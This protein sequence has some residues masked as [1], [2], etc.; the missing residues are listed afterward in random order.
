MS[1]KRTRRGRPEGSG[2]DDRARLQAIA[3][4]ISANPELKPTT[5]IRTLGI[6]DPSVIRRLRDKFKAVRP[7]LMRDLR[8]TQPQERTPA[9]LKSRRAMAASTRSSP[10][11]RVAL[12]AQARTDARPK[13]G[14][15]S[16]RSASGVAKLPKPRITPSED[17]SDSVPA[18]LAPSA[19]ATQIFTTL[20]SAGVAATN[21][22]MAAHT[23]LANGFIQSPYMSLALRQQLVLSEWAVRLVPA[24][25]VPTKTAT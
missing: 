6:S 19:D 22:L 1:E 13:P 3:R 5:A 20:I 16:P 9:G 14:K 7:E 23:T 10:S 15:P 4:L 2:I 12:P 11:S 21:T 24:F 18:R 17:D 8:S 25:Q